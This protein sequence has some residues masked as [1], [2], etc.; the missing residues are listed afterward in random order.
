M[1][2]IYRIDGRYYEPPP[3]PGKSGY[4][5]THDGRVI[6]VSRTAGPWSEVEPKD[7][8]DIWILMV[9]DPLG[10]IRVRIEGQY[11]LYEDQ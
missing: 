1:R 5:R 6:P 11:K 2:R 3:F 10:R 8:D 9:R 7:G 4:Q